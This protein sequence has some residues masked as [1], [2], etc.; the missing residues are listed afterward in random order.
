MSTMIERF[1]PIPFL[2]LNL[3]IR[4]WGYVKK[5]ESCWLW[6]GCKNSK[7]YGTFGIN[8]KTYIATR[9]AYKIQVNDPGTKYVLHEI[10]CNN[11]SCVRGDHLYLGTNSDN[12]RQMFLEGRCNRQGELSNWHKLKDHEVLEI[13]ASNLSLSA[14]GRKYGVTP[15][16]VQGIQMNTTRIDI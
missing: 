9:I 2:D 16:H 7:G 1:L 10:G 3:Q 14:L 12:M 13:R 8:H 5:T 15:S 11:P 6:I 4:F